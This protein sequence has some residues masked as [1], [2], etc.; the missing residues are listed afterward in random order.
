MSVNIAYL[1]TG[2]NMGDRVEQLRK[3]VD[4]LRSDG[5]DVSRL[6]PLYETA[7]WGREDQPPFVNQALEVK[8]TLG[9]RQL[10]RHVLRIEKKMGRVREEKYGPRVIDI[11]ILLFNKEIHRYPLLQ[12]PH[13]ELP[14][15]RFALTPLADLAPAMIHPVTQQSIAEMLAQCA[16][17]LPVQELSNA[18]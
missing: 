13:P 16:D 8:T 17:P 3:A 10:L 1:L 14:N 9:P 12:L 4:W 11:D 5:M 18:R 7:A 2:S 6:S 15:R